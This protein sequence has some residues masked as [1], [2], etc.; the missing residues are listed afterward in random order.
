MRVRTRTYWAPKAESSVEEYE[1]AFWPPR[2]VAASV[3]GFRCALGDGA[4][5]SSFSGLW[6]RLLVH[7]Y[8]RRRLQGRR[9]RASLLSLGKEWRAQAGGGPLPWYAEQKLEQGA[10]STL[11]GL[12]LLEN[13][14]WRATAVGD[15][16]LFQVRGG[17]LLC[18]FPLHDPEQFTSAP[19]LISSTPRYND[20]LSASLQHTCGRWQRGDIFLLMTDAVA[21]WFL[22]E[23]R[24][25]RVPAMPTRRPS[26][27]PWLKRQRAGGTLRNDDTTILRVEMP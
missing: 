10:F 15:T 1:D 19:V 4:T 12:H 13:G 8:C 9:T 22:R 18:S 5:E 24:R 16:C 20:R 21:C 2:D 25:G 7:A 6:A 23:T 3:H 17:S 27:G 14:T 11:L 26:Y